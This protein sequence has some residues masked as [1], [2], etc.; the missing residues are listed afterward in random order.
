MKKMFLLI[1]MMAFFSTSSI[2]SQTLMDYVSAVKGD[3]LVIKDYYE[4][5]KQ[6]NSLVYALFLDTVDV[7]VSRVYELKANG[8]YPHWLTPRTYPNRHTVIVGS[9]PTPVVNNRNAKSSPPLICTFPMTVDPGP[10]GIIA[11]GDLTIKNC[12]LCAVGAD[13]T[14]GWIFAYTTRPNLHLV[15]DNCIME[16]TLWAFVYS[17]YANC[18]FTFKDCYFVNMSGRTGRSGGVFDCFEPQDTLL[19]ENCTHVMAQG[20]IY[21]I[22]QYPF[23]RIIINHNT[24]INC[25]GSVFANPGFQGNISLT[26]NIFVNSNVHPYDHCRHGDLIDPDP[27]RLPVGL[28]NVNPYSEDSA[29]STSRKFLVQNNLVYWDSSL[30]D[31]DSILNANKVNGSTCWESQMIIMNSRTKKMFDDDYKY[32]FL[33]TDTWKNR[34]PHF[35]DPKDLF[36]KQLINIKEFV[37]EAADDNNYFVLPTWRLINIGI[38]KVV[39]PDWPIPIDLSYSDADLITGGIG[40]FP[41]GDLNWFPDKKAKWSAQRI[42]EYDKINDA[43]NKGN[44]VTAVHN[45]VNLPVEF[46]LKQNYPN[47]FNPSTTIVFSLPKSANTSLKIFDILGREVEILVEG[48]ITSG[49]HEVKFNAADLAS[50]VYFYKLKSGDFTEVKKMLLMK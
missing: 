5:N 43:L 31:C 25:A 44:L 3:T 36:T 16:R 17:S 7:P 11:E 32:P 49:M 28:V 40:G 22:K 9:D 41:L 2:F 30:D 12:E 8:Y 46:Q 50:G 20:S 38:E 23:N 45:Q 1:V 14:V 24:F 29:N 26:N 10:E 19:I 27:D 21:S 15:F 34:M 35:A 13:G 18:N 47:P 42:A 37:L 4:M 6:P 39:H 48:Y 33:V